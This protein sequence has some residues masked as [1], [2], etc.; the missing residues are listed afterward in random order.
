[1]A[2]ERRCYWHQGSR[3]DSVDSGKRLLCETTVDA[4][5]EVVWSALRDPEKIEQWFGWGYDGLT[6]EINE[7][8]ITTPT[9]DPQQHAL[10]FRGGDEMVLKAEGEQTLF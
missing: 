6:D 2:Q 7:I 9:E 8:F 5:V 10:R 1:M 3:M 4:P